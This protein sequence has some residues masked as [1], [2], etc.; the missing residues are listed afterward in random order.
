MVPYARATF[1]NNFVLVHD[2]ATCHTAHHTRDFLAQEQVEVMPW[3]ANSPDMNPIEHIW[4]QMGAHIRD[5]ANP[6]T[7]INELRWAVQ[8]AWDA[9]TV[10]SIQNLVDGMPRRVT[11]LSRAREGH[12]KY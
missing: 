6:P 1:Q 7:N 12:T 11:A 3:P 2:N 4:D 8:Q 10:E 5:M 9:V